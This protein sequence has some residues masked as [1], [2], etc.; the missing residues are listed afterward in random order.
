MTDDDCI[1]EPGW[2]AEIWREFAA[3]S[4]LGLIGGRV[5]LYDLQDLPVGIRTSR[6]RQNFEPL[7]LFNHVIG[8]NMAFRRS[9]IDQVGTFDGRFGAGSKLQSAE[10][11]DFVFRTAKTG[12]KVVYCPDIVLY[13]HHGR[14]TAQQRDTLFRS[15]RI[16][17]GAFYAKHILQ[18]DRRVLRL[19][20]WEMHGLLRNI[21]GNIARFRETSAEIHGLF[22]VSLGM[23]AYA[24][25]YL[26]A[27]LLDQKGIS[28]VDPA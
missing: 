15:Y 23:I 14:R 11:S 7:S 21:I 17:R 18:S 25:A 20:F 13:H 8:C 4:A 12:I 3:D 27:R 26:G 22:D 2:I 28:P 24:R 6:E 19:A 5:E 10:D 16:G 1:V 9:T